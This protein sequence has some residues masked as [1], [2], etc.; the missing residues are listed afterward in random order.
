MQNTL[1]Q[2]PTCASVVTSLPAHTCAYKSKKK[3][4]SLGEVKDLKQEAGFGL[5][6]L[7]KLETL[8][9]PLQLIKREGGREPPGIFHS[10]CHG[11]DSVCPYITV[12]TPAPRRQP[13]LEMESR[14]Q[15][16][17]LAPNLS[18]MFL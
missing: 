3:C 10:V 7:A 16:A 14:F 11:L 12:L 4:L 15:W 9:S 13:Y 6:S 18:L 1:G 5:G 2:P 17:N 8:Y